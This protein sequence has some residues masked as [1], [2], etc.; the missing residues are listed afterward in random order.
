MVLLV[1]LTS[2]VKMVVTAPSAL[3]V[4]DI[5][6]AVVNASAA[7]NIV[8][9]PLHDA[10]NPPEVTEFILV[11]SADE[12]MKIFSVIAEASVTVH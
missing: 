2:V 5:V 8:A 6:N 3:A 7:D 4:S 11:Q 10:E 9:E 12:S 1:G